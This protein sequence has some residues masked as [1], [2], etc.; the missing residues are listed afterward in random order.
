MQSTAGSLQSL[1]WAS[2]A[3]GGIASAYFSGALVDAYGP[4]GVFGLTAVFPLL[5]SLSAVFISEQPIVNARHKRDTSDADN[6]ETGWHFLELVACSI[7]STLS[8]QKMCI[9]LD[10]ENNQVCSFKMFTAQPRRHNSIP[11][12]F[13]VNASMHSRQ[14]GNSFLIHNTAEGSILLVLSF[15]FL[16]FLSTLYHSQTC[17]ELFAAQ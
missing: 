17:F 7:P 2:S 14:Q 13:L 12:P 4:R 3:V 16:L 11:V 10:F 6:A 15:L 9:L 1:C 5:V 8:L